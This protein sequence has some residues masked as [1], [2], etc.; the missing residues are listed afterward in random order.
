[1]ANYLGLD[2]GRK[3]VGLSSGS[4][5]PGI[6]LPGGALPA[7]NRAFC[8]H[9]IADF[10]REMRVDVVVVGYPFS[11]D[12]SKNNMCVY[13]DEFVADL[14]LLTGSGVTF[15]MFDECLTSDQAKADLRVARGTKFESRERKRKLRRTGVVDSNAAAIILQGYLD[16]LAMR[17]QLNE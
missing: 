12:G 8:L 11:L 3:R 4:D 10:I 1:M 6:A 9:K 17:T 14:K 15:A 16:E 13:V 7:S 2:V 5:D